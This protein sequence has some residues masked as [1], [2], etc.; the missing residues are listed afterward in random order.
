MGV[1]LAALWEITQD[2]L[3]V[4]KGQSQVILELPDG[5]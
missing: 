5:G 2:E 1:D 3:P 4:L